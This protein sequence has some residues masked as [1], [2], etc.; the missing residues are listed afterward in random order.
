MSNNQT[1]IGTCLATHLSNC[2]MDSNKTNRLDLTQYS[3]RSQVIGN[4]LEKL[5][6]DQ[7]IGDWIQLPDG[8][9]YTLTFKA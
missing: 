1:K 6:A 7:Q 9:T 2:I 4:A 5:S 8:T 3:T